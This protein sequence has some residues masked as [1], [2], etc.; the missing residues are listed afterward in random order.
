MMQFRGVLLLLALIFFAICSPSKK[1][2][3]KK[4]TDTENTD[5]VVQKSSIDRF[6][7]PKDPGHSWEELSRVFFITSHER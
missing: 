2:S 5:E 7:K 4:S 6:Y 3:K 1:A